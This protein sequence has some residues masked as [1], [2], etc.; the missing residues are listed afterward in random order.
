MVE[1]GRRP[2][3]GVVIEMPPGPRQVRWISDD[4]DDP[5]G[6]DCEYREY[7]LS[8]PWVVLVIVFVNGQLSNLQQAFYR[9]KAIESLDDELQYTNLLNVAQGYDQDSWVCLVNLRRCLG[10]MDWDER[11][12]TVTEH[13]WRAAFNRS[14]EEHEGNSFWGNLRGLDA[15][16]E[17]PEAWEAA[18]RDDPY[19]TLRCPGRARRAHCAPHSST[20]WKK[21][22]HRV[23]SNEWSSW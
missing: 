21:A 12:R 13:F 2:A 23:L 18:T 10:E 1:R 8:F 9:T 4:S 7:R 16:V 17:S 3:T 20:C 11:I 14:S 5:F 22:R 15:R 19:F 6:P